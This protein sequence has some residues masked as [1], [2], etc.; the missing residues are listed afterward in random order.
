MT[1]AQENTYNFKMLQRAATRALSAI[2]SILATPV[3]NE[4]RFSIEGDVN[5]LARA[6]RDIE[7]LESWLRVGQIKA[8][9]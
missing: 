9:A 2:A 3:Y 5:S 8:D 4:D 7:N 6:V 1:K